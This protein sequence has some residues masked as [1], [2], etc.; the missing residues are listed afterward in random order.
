MH[1]IALKALQE[2]PPK[3]CSPWCAMCIRSYRL[4]LEENGYGR[5]FSDPEIHRSLDLVKLFQRF[6]WGQF[7]FW[8]YSESK[9]Q[10]QILENWFEL[11]SP[12]LPDTQIHL[13]CHSVEPIPGS[14][15]K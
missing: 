5:L 12:G 9:D 1:Q 2:F 14:P 11:V 15:G 7:I 13:S 3:G 10:T 4:K 8:I 6:H